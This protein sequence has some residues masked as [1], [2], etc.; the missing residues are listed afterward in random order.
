M[1]DFV[2]LTLVAVLGLVVGVVVGWLFAR[3][4]RGRA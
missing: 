2:M 4:R 1:D 3:G